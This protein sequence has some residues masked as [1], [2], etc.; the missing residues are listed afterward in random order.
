MISGKLAAL[1]ITD[2]T[3]HIV[4]GDVNRGAID[5][6]GVFTID[7][8]D[9][10]FNRGKLINLASMVDAIDK[11]MA[12]NGMTSKRLAICFDNVFE[13][14]FSIDPVISRKKEAGLKGLFKREEEEENASQKP[15]EKAS[16]AT[17][18]HRHS[19]GQY[20]TQDEEGEAVSTSLAERDMIDSLVRE[21]EARGY[22]IVSIEAPETDLIYTRNTIPF[23]YDSLNKIIIWADDKETGSVYTMTKDVPSVIKQVQFDSLESPAFDDKIKEICLREVELGHMRNPFV[24]LIGDAFSDVIE[25]DDIA[26]ELSYEGITVIDLYGNVT[27]YSELPDAVQIRRSENM[28]ELSDD[29]TCSYGL[30]ICLLLRCLDTEPENLCEKRRF[31]LIS[32]KERALLVQLTRVSAVIFFAVNLLLTGLIAYEDM[33]VKAKV[34][35]S[36]TLNIRL[37]QAE[38]KKAK[39]K[40]QLNE[41]NTIDTRIES[42]VN[43]VYENIDSTVNIA[44]IDTVDMIP[45]SQTSASSYAKT[46]DKTG[47]E[48]ENTDVKSEDSK[49][50]NE[51]SSSTYA[52]KQLIIR[53]YSTRSA[54][55]IELYN[56]LNLLGIGEIKLAGQQQ[57]ELP[58]GE[59]IYVFEFQTVEGVTA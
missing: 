3:I 47:A 1:H 40:A 54:G 46:E 49:K 34:Q 31:R 10:F 44:S 39:A 43:F 24:Y 15:T 12:T 13:V 18:R 33:S 6:I 55:P 57:V 41:L 27:D 26:E 38:T 56:K 42:I 58:S 16:A 14:S 5:I 9:R 59:V 30:C 11:Q 35:D 32:P 48:A 37:S 4:E 21:F 50:E 20:V 51:S 52:R 7:N 53:G 36:E 23:S 17:I 19:W 25:Y 45:Q 29:V 28:S 2:K 22:K 8:T